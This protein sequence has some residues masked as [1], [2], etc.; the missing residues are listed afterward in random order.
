MK[1]ISFASLKDCCVLITVGMI[2]PAAGALG[3]MVL[4]DRVGKRNNE[5]E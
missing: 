2:V 4:L 1:T 3:L 5:R